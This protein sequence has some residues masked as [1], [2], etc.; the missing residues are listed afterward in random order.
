MSWRVAV[1][2]RTAYRYQGEVRSSYNEA[3]VTPLTTDRQLV[4]EASVRVSPPT[5]TYRYWDYWGTMV[6]AFDV[7]EPHRELAV[8]GSSVVETAPVE[9]YEHAG[10]TWEQLGRPTVTDRFAELL[11]P[12]AYVPRDDELGEVGAALASAART[13]QD[14]CETA[15]EWVHGRLGYRQGT[16]NVSTTAPEALRVGTG[17][18]Q[19]FAHVTL[20]L[21]RAVGVPARYVSGYTFPS[22]RSEV[23]MD[24]EGESHAWVEAWTGDWVAVD[25][26][27]A[28]PVGERHVI[29]ARGRDY[30]DVAPLKGIYRGAPAEALEVRVELTRLA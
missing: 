18:C 17:V 14:L 9:A 29:V 26:T 6:D 15:V 20:G 8:T 11:A 5:S 7:H 3:R 13:P 21:L 28:V 24:V 4:V 10:A 19:D 30:A 22:A 1:R 27:H 16:T 2:H 12:T 23:G 25:P